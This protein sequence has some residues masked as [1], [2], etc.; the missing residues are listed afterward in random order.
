MVGAVAGIVAG[1]VVGGLCMAGSFGIGSVGCAALAGLVGGFVGGFVGS[2]VTAGLDSKDD[3]FGS[4]LGGA[5][6]DGVIGG[7]GGLV[8]GAI[9]GKIVGALLK[10]GANLLTRIVV[11]AFGDAASGAPAGA[12][13]GA[14]YAGYDYLSNCGGSCSWSGAASAMGNAAT[15][16]AISGAIFGAAGGAFGGAYARSC[17]SF[18]PGTRVAMADGTTKPIKDVTPGDRVNATD[19]ITGETSARTV[20]AHHINQDTDLTDITISTTASGTAGDGIANKALVGTAAAA[21]ATT[22]V[23]TTAHHP[24]WNETTNSWINAAD[25]TPGD[26]LLTADG[27]AATVAMV[28]T[29]TAAQ[30]MHDHRRHHPHVLCNSWPDARLGPQLRWVRRRPRTA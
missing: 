25:L 22:V 29:K 10:P 17:H 16:G 15:D 28:D 18:A 9:G 8:G 12:F 30:T 2:L 19:P 23:H 3:S 24:F 27:S 6:V 26:Q 14:A 1:A 13:T 11:G 20:T 4:A 21:A 5:L 7:V